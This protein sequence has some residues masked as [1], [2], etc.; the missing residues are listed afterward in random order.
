MPRKRLTGGPTERGC[1]VGNFSAG[2]VTAYLS[3]IFVT[4]HTTLSATTM[5]PCAWCVGTPVM[6]NRPFDERARCAGPRF[7][8]GH[9]YLIDVGP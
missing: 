7:V 9:R 3:T 8:F 1:C 2:D 6:G 4:T 5:A